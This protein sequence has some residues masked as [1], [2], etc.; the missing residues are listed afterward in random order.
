MTR[1]V[2]IG[3]EDQMDIFSHSVLNKDPEPVVSMNLF[4]CQYKPSVLGQN[5]SRPSSREF[6]HLR[7]ASVSSF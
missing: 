2:R 1:W 7:E 3:D 4:S 5:Q 6:E